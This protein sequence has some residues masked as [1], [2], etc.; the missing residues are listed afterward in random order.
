MSPLSE[1]R[2][3]GKPVIR[4]MSHIIILHDTVCVGVSA[5]EAEGQGLMVGWEHN[6][7]YVTV[8]QGLLCVHD[9]LIVDLH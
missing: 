1:K 2:D 5:E 3:K 7:V 4:E 6:R 9:S 8:E